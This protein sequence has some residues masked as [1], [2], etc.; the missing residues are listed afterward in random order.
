MKITVQVRAKF[1]VSV[2]GVCLGLLVLLGMFARTK[3]ALIR[4]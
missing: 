2:G 1:Q 3:I 4:E